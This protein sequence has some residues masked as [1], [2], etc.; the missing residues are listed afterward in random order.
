MDYSVNIMGIVIGKNIKKDR[1]QWDFSD[2]VVGV[3][4]IRPYKFPAKES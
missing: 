2:R 4:G 3:Y 1:M